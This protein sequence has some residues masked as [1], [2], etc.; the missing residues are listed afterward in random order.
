[1]AQ[2]IH[3]EKLSVRGVQQ[4]SV[5]IYSCSLL[6]ENHNSNSPLTSVLT[7][8]TPLIFGVTTTRFSEF[9]EIPISAA[10]TKA[11]LVGLAAYAAS[12]VFFFLKLRP[13][14]RNSFYLF[15]AVYTR[16][17]GLKK[18]PCCYFNHGGITPSCV[19]YVNLGMDLS[20]P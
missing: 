5:H 2:S 3:V 1:M 4:P 7:K 13:M 11:H 8:E 12:G 20:I 9:P 14:H 16:E 17:L 19:C 6:N 15:N 18:S 10:K